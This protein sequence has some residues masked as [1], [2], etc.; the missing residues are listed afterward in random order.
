MNKLLR[1]LNNKDV[2]IRIIHLSVNGNI[3]SYL[4]IIITNF[5]W[6]VTF[7]HTS[8]L[9]FFNTIPRYIFVA[10]IIVF[11]IILDFQQNDKYIG[12]TIVH[13]MYFRSLCIGITHRSIEYA[14]RYI[15]ICICGMPVECRP[16]YSSTYIPLLSL[17]WLPNT[18]VGSMKILLFNNMSACTPRGF[19]LLPHQTV[20]CI[21][22]YYFEHLL[23]YLTLLVVSSSP[24]L[25]S[26]FQLFSN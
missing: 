18:V 20:Y 6:I 2:C 14:T 8:I 1:R 15:I 22:Y 12:F 24:F 9:H 11:I 21:F 17:P 4:A 7:I 5:C 16:L 10:K 3:T 26:T 19:A 25:C 13:H 23:L